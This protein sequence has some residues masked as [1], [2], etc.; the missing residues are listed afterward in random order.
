[1]KKALLS[2]LSIMAVVLFSA[3]STS[4]VPEKNDVQDQN[5]SKQIEEQAPAD[6][7]YIGSWSRLSTTVNGVPQDVVPATITMTADKYESSTSRCSLSGDLKM[8]DETMA[9]SITKYNCPGNAPKNYL[10]SYT[11]SKD[12]NTLTTTNTQFGSSVVE[13]YERI[14]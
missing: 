11:I 14:N 2:L 9:I 8:T 10:N 1:M 6:A 12:G 4:K 13:V 7:D 3:C 5:N